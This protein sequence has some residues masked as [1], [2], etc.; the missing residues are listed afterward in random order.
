M[1]Y[2]V[3]IADEALADIFGLVQNIYTELSNPDA[4]EK[5]YE[6]LYRETKTWEIFH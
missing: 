4:A 3:L 2:R 5:L 6:N 1:N